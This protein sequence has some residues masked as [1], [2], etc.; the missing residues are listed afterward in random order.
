M[1]NILGP[2]GAV[3]H[4]ERGNC[5]IV[6]ILDQVVDA[7]L[8]GGLEL[9]LLQ[10]ADVDIV[11]DDRG[12]ECLRSETRRSASIASTLMSGGV[13]G[14]LDRLSLRDVAENGFADLLK[15][16]LTLLSGRLVGRRALGLGVR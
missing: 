5:L 1:L 9:A 13:L 2:A 10:V 12:P 4:L 7:R 6:V 14:R 15:G 3:S 11:A 16:G 8:P